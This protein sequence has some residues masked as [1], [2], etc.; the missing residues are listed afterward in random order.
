M[1]LKVALRR[2]LMWTSGD[3]TT[4]MMRF[5]SERNI[6]Q[7]TSITNNEIKQEGRLQ[8]ISR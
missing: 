2:M 5:S 7:F 4:Y 3:M 8:L 6:E 1:K